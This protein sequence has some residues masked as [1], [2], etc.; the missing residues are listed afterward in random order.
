LAR[1]INNA[2]V[3]LGVCSQIA[4]IRASTCLALASSGAAF[5]APNRKSS[6]RVLSPAIF[7]SLAGASGSFF[8]LDGASCGS[9]AE[10]IAGA[11]ARIAAR[12]TACGNLN[13]IHKL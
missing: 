13:A 4:Q 6:P 1:N 5:S 7:G 2:A 10:A 3:S 12:K 11:K 8:C 9:C